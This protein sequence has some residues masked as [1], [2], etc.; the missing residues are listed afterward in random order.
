MFPIVFVP[1]AAQAGVRFM[2]KLSATIIFILSLSPAAADEEYTDMIYTSVTLLYWC[3]YNDVPKNKKEISKV[4][5]LDEPNSKITIGFDEWRK[6]LSYKIN[7][8]VMI[9]TKGNTTS[10]SNCASVEVIPE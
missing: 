5:N 2:K 9:I 1:R 7:D 6:N 10:K 4:T 8:D 3:L